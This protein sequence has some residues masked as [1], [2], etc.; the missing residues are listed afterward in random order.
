MEC[1]GRIN[2]YYSPG[3]DICNSL[4]VCVNICLETNQDEWDKEEG[5]SRAVD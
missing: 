5:E 3:C 2:E 4:R 1:R